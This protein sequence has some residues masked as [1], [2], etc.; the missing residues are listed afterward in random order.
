MKNTK[1]INV[2]KATWEKVKKLFP[3]SSDSRRSRILYGIAKR[4]DLPTKLQLEPTDSK[5]DRIL[6]GV[7]KD[8]L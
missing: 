6:K 5:K 7:M 1:N 8:L 2:H 4:V 3:N